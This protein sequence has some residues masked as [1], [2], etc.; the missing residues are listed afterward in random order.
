MNAVYQ[1]PFI[2]CCLG[3]NHLYLHDAHASLGV[4]AVI[5]QSGHRLDRPKRDLNHLR[6]KSARPPAYLIWPASQMELGMI[7]GLRLPS[8]PGK[9]PREKSGSGP[10]SWTRLL[11]KVQFQSGAHPWYVYICI[12]QIYS[13]ISAQAESVCWWQTSGFEFDSCTHSMVFPW[14]ADLYMWFKPGVGLDPG[15]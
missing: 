5:N 11:T 12:Q 13:S 1:K 3:T 10:S 14:V 7:I 4:L 15:I 9:N 2:I 8:Y 6:F